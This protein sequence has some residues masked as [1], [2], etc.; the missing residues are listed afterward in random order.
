MEIIYYFIINPAAGNGKGKKVW[1]T[2]LPVLNKQG[3]NYLWDYT[4]GPSHAKQLAGF[5]CKQKRADII[6]A[7]G[8]DGTVHEVAN[9][10]LMET[11][12]E[13][14]LGCIPAGSG[15]DF[16][17]VLG[18]SNNPLEA[19]QEILQGRNL[20]MDTV[21]VRKETND[22]QIAV[23]GLGIGFDGQ[24]AH[25]VNKSGYKAWLNRFGLGKLSYI[26]G[27]LQVIFSY[28]PVTA[29]IIV[30]GKKHVISR[31]W[32]I[33]VA[34]IPYY[35]GG[36]MICPGA[37][38]DDGLLDL[39]IVHGVSRMT[40]IRLFPRVYSG[41]HTSHEGVTLLKG[42]DIQ[43][44]TDRPVYI[45]GDGESFGLTPAGIVCE[46]QALQVRIAGK[47]K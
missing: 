8:G 29:E 46:S 47:E 42:S 17:R 25:V 11:N 27:F 37:K 14:I 43:I 39:C 38:K 45:Q 2:L 7:I 6:V 31:V 34:N 9:G 24:V 1:E 3:I 18:M 35:G 26:F 33:A 15:N 36:M 13:I 44:Q 12:D 10:M 5:V 19:W 16:A 4:K 32:L 28:R 23:N 40:L 41:T 20:L 21:F 22:R 30:D